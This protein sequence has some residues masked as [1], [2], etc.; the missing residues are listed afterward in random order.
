MKLFKHKFTVFFCI[1]GFVQLTFAQKIKLPIEILGAENKTEERRFNLTADQLSKVAVL[2]LQ[3]NNLSYEDKASIRINTG[4]WQTLNHQTVS[5]L[6]PEKER[7]GMSHGG[8]NTIRFTIP[9]NNF[10]TGDINILR[11]RFNKSDGISNGFRVIKFNLLDA[12]SQEILDDSYFEEDDPATW[13]LP[14]SDATSIAK[15]KDLWFNADLESNYL[16]VN[17]KG[18]WYSQELS[19]AK[20]IKAKCASCHTQDGRDLEIFSYSNISIIERAKF[21]KLTEEEGKY[22]A[23]YIRSLSDEHENVGRYGRPWNPPYQPG[24]EVANMPIKEWAAGAGLDAVLE[25]DEE[26][27]P[28][29]FPNGVNQE[30]V[31]DRFDSDKMYDRT[32]MPIAI[33]FPDWKHW[34]PMIHPMDAYSNGNFYQQSY[35]D[36]ALYVNLN[37]S[38]MNPEKGYEIFRQYLVNA[39]KKADGVTVD[40][41][42]MSQNRLEILKEQHRV[43]RL[44]FRFYQAQGGDLNKHWRSITG[45]GLNSLS[46]DVP[47]DFAAT[48]LARLMAVKNF[49]FMNE[50]NMQD[51][52]PSYMLPEDQPNVRQWF[53]HP[54]A[55]HVFEIPAHITGCLDGDCQ[56]FTT[57]PRNVGQFESTNW[58]QV[59][60][61]LAPGNGANSHNGPVDN[62]YQAEFIL[63]SGKSSGIY[64]PLRYYNSLNL[65]YQTKTWSGDT[66]PNDGNGFRIRVQGPWYFLGKE[67]DAGRSQ[68]HSFTPG[69]W[70]TTLDNVQQGLTRM[71]LNAQFKQFLKEINKPQ[72]DLNNWGRFDS[73]LPGYTTN[74]SQNLDSKSKNSIRDVTESFNP[75][76]PLYADHMYW[77]IDEAYK[78]GVDVAILQEVLVWCIKAW[79]FINWDSLRNTIG[80][81]IISLNEITIHPN[82]VQTQLIIKGLKNNNKITVFDL[83]GRIRF[84][85]KI[86]ESNTNLNL[87]NL[88]D[89]IY[90]L[91]ITNSKNQHKVIKFLKN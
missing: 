74:L 22:I 56:S 36:R 91:R 60:S 29:M 80:V 33:Q 68:F 28:Y 10:R 82:P 37:S 35:D 46:T 61:V 2:W 14:F 50:F 40:I 45:L 16:P 23:S 70:P 11:F 90:F 17:R 88:N 31:Y 48:S 6:S 30:T 85:K 71:V 24:P 87:Q 13:K 89:G 1:L 65:M 21:H 72:N 47:V 7:G 73:P 44:H 51:Q 18:F 63:K 49:E 43:F 32:I 58:Y 66:N 39:P 86:K 19:G 9:I 3:V 83:L 55:K 42:S 20:P 52:A 12:N 78:L 38:K 41:A 69:F 26:M 79:P 67:A 57:Q 34:L 77:S 4:S 15:G 81:E 53:H 75:D 64:E 25:K 76:D 8:Y 5:I 59:Q 62:N 54:D 84:S 27:L